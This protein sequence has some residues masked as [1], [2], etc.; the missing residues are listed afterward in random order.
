[1]RAGNVEA[2]LSGWRCFPLAEGNYSK[3]ARGNLCGSY[4]LVLV[5]MLALTLQLIAFFHLLTPSGAAA[6]EPYD[7][8]QLQVGCVEPRLR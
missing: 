2:V 6:A 7:K 4:H 8:E 5:E 3:L 1:M